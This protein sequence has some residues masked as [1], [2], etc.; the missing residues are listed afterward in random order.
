MNQINTNYIPREWLALKINACKMA[1]SKLP[2]TSLHIRSIRSVKTPV[3][4]VNGHMF[5]RK[6]E[7][8]RYY[9]GLAEKREQYEEQLNVAECIW[10]SHFKGPIPDDITPRTVVRMFNIGN[11][12]RVALDRAYFDSL[13]NDADPYYPESKK[14]FFNGIYYRS[15]AEKEIAEFYTTNGIPFKYEPEVW[16]NGM[17]KPIYPDFVV[18]IKEI[19]CCKFHEH[20]GLMNFVNYLKT[21]KNKYIMYTE[22]GLIPDLDILFTYDT[23]DLPFDLRTLMPR[24]NSMIYGS[25]FTRQSE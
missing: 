20:L 22:A 1:L 10:H 2:D 5:T 18:Y 6:T 24:L 16:I 9:F 25:L 7:K 4:I 12:E 21:T 15:V 23:D 11:G 13:K 8:G 3:C 14:Y 19:D 17:N